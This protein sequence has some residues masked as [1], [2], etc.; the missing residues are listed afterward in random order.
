L[1]VISIPNDLRKDP[2]ARK[3]YINDADAVI[4]CESTNKLLYEHSEAKFGPISN[5]T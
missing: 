4:L 1:E 2:E 5:F 3:K